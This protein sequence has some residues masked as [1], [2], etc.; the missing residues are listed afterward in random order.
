MKR[1]QYTL[2]ELLVVI[3]IIALLAGLLLPALNSSRISARA[4]ACISNQKQ[5]VTAIIQSISGNK[6]RFYSPRYDG[7]NNGASDATVRWSARLYNRKYL[8]DYKTMRC[9]ETI[10]PPPSQGSYREDAFTYGAVYHDAAVTTGFD[11]RG[12][13]CLTTSGGDDV[14]PTKLMLGGCSMNSNHGGGA[15]LDLSQSATSSN[16]YGTLSLAHRDSVNMFFLDGRVAPVNKA[17]LDANSTGR[18]LYYPTTANGPA[19]LVPAR[20][21]NG[22]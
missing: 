1:E 18:T 3:G 22:K 4:A 20:Y 8:Q 16:S 15:L 13:R 10:F 12:T 9:T 14:P 11:F 7:T 21:N 2:I 5:V 17:E 6:D 19:G